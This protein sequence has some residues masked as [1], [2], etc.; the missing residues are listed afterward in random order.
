MIFEQI[1]DEGLSQYSYI[2][3]SEESGRVAVVDPR[4][5][6]D[7]YLSYAGERDLEIGYV[8]ETH[9]HADFASG[10]REL[11]QRAKAGLCLSAHDEGE[12]YEVSFDH[13]ELHDGDVIE[14]GTIRIQAEHTPGHTPEHLS[15]VVFGDRSKTVPL[16]M[17]TG[18]FLFVGSLGRPDLLGE[19]AEKQMTEQFFASTRQKIRDLPDGLEIYP[20]HGAGSM[21]GSG[22]STRP[23]STLGFERLTNPLLKGDLSKSDFIEL[24]RKSVPVFP[25]YYRRM[26]KLNSEGPPILGPLPGLNPIGIEA[27][28]R[29][30][31]EGQ[32]VVDVRDHR[33][34]GAGH[35]PDSYGIGAGPKLSLWAS[36]VLPYDRPLMLVAPDRETVESAVRSLIR[37]GLDEISGFLEGGMDEWVQAGRP[38]SRVAQVSPSDLYSRLQEGEEITVL[39]VRTDAE[40]KEGHIEGAVHI[41]GGFFREHL[42]R[43]P[44]DNALAIICGSGYRSTV[45][46]SILE[47]H[48]FGNL[49]NVTGGM[50]AW[51]QASLPVTRKPN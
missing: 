25:P 23:R 27:F 15:Y 46:A 32:V 7:V 1:V 50:Q 10:A 35:I 36:W 30:R 5:D 6:I 43:V 17:L 40:W 2:V 34:F 51:A 41:F 24:L 19:E 28:T 18:D 29:C 26:K 16:L 3:G 4:R 44:E 42:D 37:V 13:T 47:Q 14:L 48:G 21:C 33:T 8:L 49:M 11:A 39:D 20:G 12:Q 9:I 45:A 31:E 22:M 38:L